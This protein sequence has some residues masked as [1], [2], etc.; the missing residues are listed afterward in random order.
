[1]LAARRVMERHT[2]GSVGRGSSI[3]MLL[4]SGEGAVWEVKPLLYALVQDIEVEASTLCSAV[5]SSKV[6]SVRT[7]LL[8]LGTRFHATT[9]AR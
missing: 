1:M 8:E 2:G 5:Y 7:S 3:V 9:S 4:C 6:W